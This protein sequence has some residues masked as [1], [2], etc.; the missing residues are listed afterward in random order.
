M[1][2][3]IGGLRIVTVL[4][5]FIAPA[6]FAA[7][8][9]PL[10]IEHALGT[11]T[12]PAE[13]QRVVALIDRDVDTL[14]ALGVQPVG[15]N[16]LYGFESGAG[17]WS[18]ALLGGSEPVVWTGRE[19]NYEAI[20][21]LHPDLIVY[22]NSGGEADIYQRLSAIAPTVALPKGATGWEATVQQ[23]TQLIAD[24]LG[25]RDDGKALLTKL[26]TYLA[27][28]K[29]AH[30]EFAGKSANYL[31]IYPGGISSYSDQHIVNGMLYAVGFSPVAAATAIPA[32]QSSIAV[33]AELLPDYDADI[34][35]IYP[36]GRSLAELEAETPTLAALA[37]VTDGRAFVLDNLAF[38]TAS[39]LSI[40]YALDQLVPEFSAALSK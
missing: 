4:A 18:E 31:D 1:P 28:Q 13:P 36:F 35:V 29:A 7:E 22:A 27:G 40:P 33:S 3:W 21:A 2:G 37:S 5:A 26:D 25:R 9:F 17:P 10:T 11:I 19:F 38:S 12:I 6:G 8:P 23:T 39:V 24:A 34:T 32:G 14:L 16:S 30:P 15:I 20:A